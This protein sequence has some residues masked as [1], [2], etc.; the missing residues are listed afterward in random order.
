[1]QQSHKTGNKSRYS[2]KYVNYWR[3]CKLLKEKKRYKFQQNKVPTVKTSL[4]L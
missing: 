2:D 3:V 4:K 1:M